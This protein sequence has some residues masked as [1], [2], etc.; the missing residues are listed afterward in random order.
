[1]KGSE[2]E[3]RSLVNALMPLEPSGSIFP[4]IYRRKN[5]GSIEPPSLSS[6]L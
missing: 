2:S 4:S 3:K 1:M 6:C 5:R